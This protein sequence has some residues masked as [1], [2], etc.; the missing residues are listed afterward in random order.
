VWPSFT[1]P[2]GRSPWASGKINSISLQVISAMNC[3][4]FRFLFLAVAACLITVGCG[5]TSYGPTGKITGRLTLAGKPLAQ[6]TAVSFMQ[7]EKGFLAFGLTDADGKFEVTSWNGGNMPVGKYKVMIAP[8]TG[9]TTSTEEMT[10]EELFERPD[11]MDAPTSK[12]VPKKYR[13]TATS[14]LEFDIKEGA[15]E[16][17]IDLGI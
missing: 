5:G 6:G 1:K 13:D 2:T 4:R 12:D 15:N 8:A 11:L 16:I 17:P 10:P 9:G 7:M 14:D 3:R